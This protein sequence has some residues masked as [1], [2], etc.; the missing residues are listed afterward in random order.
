MDVSEDP[1]WLADGTFLW[2]SDR[3]G[4]RHVYR[5][6]QDGTLVAQVTKGPYDMKNVTRLDEAKGLLYFS[7]NGVDVSGSHLYRAPLD[8]KTAAR[9]PFGQSRCRWPFGDRDFCRDD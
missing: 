9:L 5:Y 2:T 1:T 7:G 8:G 3:D 6:Q 4:F